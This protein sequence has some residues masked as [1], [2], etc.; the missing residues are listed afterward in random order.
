[1]HL[2]QVAGSTS[3]SP[4]CEVEITGTGAGLG[5]LWR[6]DAFITLQAAGAGHPCPGPRAKESL[7]TYRGKRHVDLLIQ[8]QFQEPPHQAA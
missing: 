7:W 2:A 3:L 6:P 5:P 4:N 8:L 1:M